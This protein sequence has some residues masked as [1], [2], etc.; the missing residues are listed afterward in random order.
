[1]NFK[2]FV[3]L[4]LAALA[5]SA[6]AP[7]A[8]GAQIR[9]EDAWG[10]PSPAAASAG[11]FYMTIYNDGSEADTLLSATS[12][13]CMMAELHESYMMDNG[14]MGMRP[15]E[16]GSIEIPAGGSAELKVGGLHVMC[17][18]KMADFKTGDTYQITLKFEKAGE[19][20]VDVEIKDQ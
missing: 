16:G 8:G 14:A 10:R 5:L 1:M 13:A 12:P 18:D 2:R 20:V 11:A 4:I 15:V 7:K 9:V 3:F 17:M 19:I 6:C